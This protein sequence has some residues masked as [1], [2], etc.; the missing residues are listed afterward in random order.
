MSLNRREATA[1]VKQESEGTKL[2]YDNLPLG[3]NEG[4]LVFVADLGL[5]AREYAEE[6]KG[7]FQ[8]IALGIEIP[9]HPMKDEEGNSL[10]RILWTKAFSI[11]AKL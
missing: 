1:V 7:N 8:Q 5:Q 3:D 9:D 11:Y 10:S 4:R 2:V 6:F